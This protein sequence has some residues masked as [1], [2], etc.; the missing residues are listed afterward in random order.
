MNGQ[1]SVGKVVV[2]LENILFSRMVEK[3]DEV[4]ISYEQAYEQFQAQRKE[5]REKFNALKANTPAAE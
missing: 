3:D 5:V 1:L 2:P 4:L